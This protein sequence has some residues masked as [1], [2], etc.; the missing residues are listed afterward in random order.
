MIVL[1]LQHGVLDDNVPIFH[2]RRMHQLISLSG[3]TSRLYEL[4][5]RG[6]WFDGVMTTEHLRDFY[7]NISTHQVEEVPPH[8]VRFV[9]PS[10]GDMGSCAGIFVDQL[11]SPDQFGTVE[12]FYNAS[13]S[14]LI[15][16]TSNVFRL[17]FVSSVWNNRIRTL[18]LDGSI[19]PMPGSVGSMWLVNSGPGV[20]TVSCFAQG[21]A[22][23]T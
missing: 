15:L 11:I 8:Y 20:W 23:L 19:I 5:E 14:L 22:L 1:V 17:H 9:V 21:K 2:S 7:S 16:R 4:E 13:T 10:S 3:S 12:V 18:R 6:H